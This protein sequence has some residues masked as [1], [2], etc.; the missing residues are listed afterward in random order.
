MTAMARISWM[1]TMTVRLRTS[2]ITKF[3]PLLLLLLALS[4]S[5]QSTFNPE[6]KELADLRTKAK[7]GD[8]KAQYALGVCYADGQGVTKDYEEAVKW[9][10]KAAEQNNA[11][12]QLCIGGGYYG[13]LGVTKDYEEAVKWYRKAAE[14]N[15]AGAQLALA[16]CY[17]YGSG[18]NQ[19]YDMTI[20]WLNLAI[21]NKDSDIAERATRLK[22]QM[23]NAKLRNPDHPWLSDESKNVLFQAI[24]EIGSAAIMHIINNS[25]R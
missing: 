5:G 15:D 11:N 19:D 6:A 23:E 9:W 10:R 1:K 21:D 18:V 8:A 25:G 4:A 3:L 7:N 2:C 17:A 20:H 14:Q 12:A 24:V 22:A 13:G 16:L